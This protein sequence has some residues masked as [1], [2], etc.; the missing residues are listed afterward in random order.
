MPEYTKYAANQFID[1]YQVFCKKNQNSLKQVYTQG[2]DLQHKLHK[3]VSFNSCS[4]D[5]A[6]KIGF[7]QYCENLFNDQFTFWTKNETKKECSLN[8]K[9]CAQMNEKIFK[10]YL[11]V[12]K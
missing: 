8:A 7:S 10:N 1:V 12:E 4:D 6:N 3:I 9:S 2:I 11:Q 5:E